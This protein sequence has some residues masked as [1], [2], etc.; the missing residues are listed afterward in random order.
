MFRLRALGGCVLERDGAPL[1]GVAGQRKRLALLALLAAAGE[2]GVSRETAAAAL[3]SEV[4][5]DRAAASL[6][7][8]VH[9]VRQQL[10]APDGLLGPAVLRLNPAV[11]ASDIADFRAALAAGEHE[12]AVAA[13][14]G[15]FLDGFQVRGA[16]GFERWAA[17][18]RA[19]LAAAHRGA[20]EALAAAATSTGD[21]HAA[22]G[23]WRQL[24]AADPLSGRAA[25]ALMRTLVAVGDRAGALRHA[26]VYR[27]VVQQELG[28]GAASP[29]V[30]ALAAELARPIGAAPAAPVRTAA[31]VAPEAAPQAAPQ[32][33][34][35][36]GVAAPTANVPSATAEDAPAPAPLDTRR[37][38]ALPAPAVA[39]PPERSPGPRARWRRALMPAAGTLALVAVVAAAARG[40][41]GDKASVASRAAPAPGRVTARSV[42]VLPFANTS[43]DPANEPFADGLTDELIGALGRAPGLRVTPRTSTF[44]LKGRGLAMRTIADSLGVATALEGS[45]R[46]WGDRLRVTVSLVSVAENRVLWAETYDRAVGDVFGV[47]QEIAGGVVRALRVTLAQEASGSSG[48]PGTRD[49]I[50]YEHFLKGQF[51]RRQQTAEALDRADRVLRNAI[52]RDSGY[53]RAH[54]GLADALALRVLFADR[55]RARSTRV[56]CARRR[57]PPRS[58]RRSPTRM[59]RSGTWPSPTSGTGRRPTVSCSRRSPSTRRSPA[60]GS[61]AA[62][63]CC[64]GAASTRPLR[65]S[66]ARCAADPLAAPV[67]MTLGR[68]HLA[69]GDRRARLVLLQSALELNPRFAYAHQQLGHAYLRDGR[70]AEARAAF[71]QAAALGGASDSAQLAY[72]Y[73]VTGHRT[74][75]LALVRALLLSAERR[76]LPPFGVAMAY[77]GL[78]DA[79]AAFRWLDRAVEERAALMDGLAVAPGFAS[80]HG[81]PRWS[82][83]LRRVVP[84]Q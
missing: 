69:R 33:A 17:E 21:A 39:A 44:A 66:S 72:A 60:R 61:G 57:G 36:V 81:D 22:A 82:R 3:W 4:D 59:R 58:I 41:W 46:R 2:R 8:L 31:D 76:Y 51:F 10:G 13:Y 78:G 34:S 15:P 64:T 62:S 80:L 27:A 25:V 23:W 70:G 29:E 9:S 55:L 14:G 43:G 75:A 68:V 38:D 47:Q 30:E 54:A 19:A 28:A 16:D 42:V 49:P 50:A 5:E 65:C 18:E 7:Q 45:V 24:Q 84:P 11:V 35:H 56:P 40:V 32:A 77:A 37:D 6:K 53:A 52:A 48:P 12:R 71:A 79:D 63:H 83:L 26:R 73:G 74:E 67:R 1:D 20:L